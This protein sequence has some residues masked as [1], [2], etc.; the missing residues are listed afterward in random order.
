[1]P[2]YEYRCSNTRCG[3]S[4]YMETRRKVYCPLCAS[5][6]L[7]QPSDATLVLYFS[8]GDFREQCGPVSLREAV[9]A[10]LRVP[11]ESIYDAFRLQVRR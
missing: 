1:M 11:C 5:P 8:L 10:A 2:L 4:F 7:R 9:R 3:A 6:A